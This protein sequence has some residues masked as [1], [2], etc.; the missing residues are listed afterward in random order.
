[1]LEPHLDS[2]ASD[3]CT[4]VYARGFEPSVWI[5]FGAAWQYATVL[6]RHRYPDGWDE[7]QVRPRGHVGPALVFR[8]GQ[9]GILPAHPGRRDLRTALRD[10]A[11][12]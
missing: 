7:L 1:M 10:S 9:P 5:W 8:A 4:D 6:A 12:R 3:V 2:S 11:A